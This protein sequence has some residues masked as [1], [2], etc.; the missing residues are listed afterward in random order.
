MF[1]RTLNTKL[2]KIRGVCQIIMTLI[3]FF[4]FNEAVLAAR[5]RNTLYIS[6]FDARMMVASPHATEPDWLGYAGLGNM[7][8]LGS[9]SGNLKYNESPLR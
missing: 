7:A 6:Y 5:Y 8:A 2:K 4:G 3:S 1:I 9:D